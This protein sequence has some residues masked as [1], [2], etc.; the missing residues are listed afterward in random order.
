ML[1]PM[2]AAC[3]KRY[4]EAKVLSNRRIAPD[5]W[6]LTLEA[7]EIAAAIRPGQFVNV[8][9]RAVDPSVLLPRPFS[10]YDY[11]E[12]KGT[13]D[14][15]HQAIGSGTRA[16]SRLAAGQAVPVVGPL[17]N[18]FSMDPPA[19]RLLCVAGGIG[20]TPF[21]ALLRRYPHRGAALLFGARSKDFLFCRDELEALGAACRY[22]TDDG[23]VGRKG[24]VTALLEEE[25]SRGT[26]GVELAV[27]GPPAMMRAVLRIAN[28][29]KVPAQ[30][31]LENH[32]P[33]GLG[34]CRGCAWPVR[35]GGPEGFSYRLLCAEG[36]V[37]RSSEIL[38]P[39]GL[40]H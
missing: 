13:I 28:R 15:V 29:L 33:C 16:M 34:A 40:G 25:L 19:K 8:Y 39:P 38:W 35:G 14:L 1:P 12:S 4:V 18:G 9:P 22:A 3:R 6:K 30:L 17:G 7:P 11:D 5:G 36:P 20:V 24:F 23:S 27:C 21:Y 31:S 26:E 37:L 10:V 2:S 32:M